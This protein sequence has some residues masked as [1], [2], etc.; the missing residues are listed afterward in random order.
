VIKLTAQTHQVYGDDQ[1]VLL[2]PLAFL[3]FLPNF[4]RCRFWLG[5]NLTFLS[6]RWFL[7]RFL[8]SFGLSTFLA[9]SWS[10]LAHLP[11]LV[12]MA[13]SIRR[14]IAGLE[15]DKFNKLRHIFVNRN[16]AHSIVY[17]VTVVTN[18]QNCL[19]TLEPTSDT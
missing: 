4:D 1:V 6:C 10:L 9:S 16:G 19:M 8:G 7:N 11:L 5:F 15:C 18:I 14:L 17:K 2:V 13:T 12:D 3:R